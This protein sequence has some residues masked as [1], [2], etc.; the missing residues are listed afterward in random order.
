MF[1]LLIQET[2]P[3]IAVAAFFCFFAS[4]LYISFGHIDDSQIKLGVL[5]FGMGVPAWLPWIFA[6]LNWVN[7]S[8]LNSNFQ[9]RFSE[10]FLSIYSRMINLMLILFGIMAF[11]SSIL[12]IQLMGALGAF[13]VLSTVFIASVLS[14]EFSMEEA[15]KKNRGQ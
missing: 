13:P 5:A 8:A 7:F 11:I 2:L 6:R 9:I 15:I 12:T 4:I 3:K 14:F 10:K 1:L